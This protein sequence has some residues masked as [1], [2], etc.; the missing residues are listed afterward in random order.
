MHQPINQVRLRGFLTE[1]ARL[2]VSRSGQPRLTFRL[3]VWIDDQSLPPKKPAGVDYFSVVAFGTQFVGLASELVRGREVTVSGRLRS[4]DLDTAAQQLRK[5]WPRKSPRWRLAL[6]RS[7]SD[8]SSRPGAKPPRNPTTIERGGH[9]VNRHGP[10]SP[11]AAGYLAPRKATRSIRSDARCH[12][13][14]ESAVDTRAVR[15]R[16]S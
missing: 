6:R 4:R 2:F 16:W 11:S 15:W 3:E 5:L 8:R 7:A 9:Q 12:P 14:S 1:S 10:V 13:I